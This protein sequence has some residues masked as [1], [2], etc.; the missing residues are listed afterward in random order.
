ME[1]DFVKRE[2]ERL[3]RHMHDTIIELRNCMNIKFITYSAYDVVEDINSA[4]I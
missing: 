1:Y 4:A 2:S 3:N